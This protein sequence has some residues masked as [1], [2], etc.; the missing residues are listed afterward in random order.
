MALRNVHQSGERLLTPIEFRNNLNEGLAREAH[1]GPHPLIA[2][3]AFP[4]STAARGILVASE[5]G[6]GKSVVIDGIMMSSLK[7]RVG[8]IKGHRALVHDHKCNSVATMYGLGLSFENGTL[9]TLNPYDKRGSYW[10]IADD[11]KQHSD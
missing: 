9:K 6:G 2:G 3:H 4:Y 7:G 8:R 1:L 5:R 10:N 11:I